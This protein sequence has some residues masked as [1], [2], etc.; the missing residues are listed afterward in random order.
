MEI[1]YH[2][3]TLYPDERH[4][5]ELPWYKALK[6]RKA[7]VISST[8]DVTSSHCS[9]RSSYRLKSIDRDGRTPTELESW[10]KLLEHSD[11]QARIRAVQ[12]HLSCITTLAALPISLGCCERK[13]LPAAP[14]AVY[15][16]TTDEIERE[17]IYDTGAAQ[18]MI[19][20]NNLTDEEKS[21]TYKVETQEFGT[22]GGMVSHHQ[23]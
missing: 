2:Y 18:T 19:G 3:F 11:K 20:W 1:D 12:M 22:A 17:W 14:A 15:G 4:I 23:Q 9:N 8:D 21:R 5:A 7:G 10:N 13:A 16:L 6:R